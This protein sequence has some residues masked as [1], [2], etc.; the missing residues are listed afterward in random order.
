MDKPKIELKKVRT[1]SGHEGTGVNAEMWVDGVKTCFV[2]DDASGSIMYHFSPVYNRE[3]FKLLEDY[4]DSLPE[5]PLEI[6]GKPFM[7]DDKPV[8]HKLRIEDVFDEA[9]EEW[10]AKKDWAK[11]EKKFVDHIIWGPDKFKDI[12]TYVKFK[13]PLSSIPTEKLQKLVDK[14]KEGLQPGQRFYNTNF[15]SLKIKV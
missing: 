11:V 3:K 8:M 10:V 1:F 5:E 14:Y 12:Y 13:V 2:L 6:E 7:R 9:F 4:V 15:E